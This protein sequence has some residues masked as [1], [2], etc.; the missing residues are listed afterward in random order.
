MY[1]ECDAVF[2]EQTEVSEE[3]SVEL[4]QVRVRKPRLHFDEMT[5][6]GGNYANV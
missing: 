4:P 5:K 6:D 2:S 3:D 1:D